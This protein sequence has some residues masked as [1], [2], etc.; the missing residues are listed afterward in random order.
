MIG[1]ASRTGTARNLAALRGAGWHLLVSARGALRTEGFPYALDNGAWTAHQK[2][3]PLCEDSFRRAVDL[4]GAGAQFI[5]LPDIVGGCH[6]SLSYSLSWLG[7]L[8]WHPRLLLPVQDGMV[9]DDVRP[10][11]GERVG[12]AVGG[13]PTDDGT[14]EWKLRTL[15]LWGRLARETGCYL[16]VLRVNSQRR[17]RQ[18]QDVG[19]HSFDGSGP[20]R[21]SKHL[22]VLDAAVRQRH[23]WEN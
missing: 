2:G 14:T 18:C 10:Y 4:L 21:F 7:R 12:L 20:S 23:L 8:A 13:A 17:I 1:Y 16:H 11:L 3:E 6:D 19:A 22:V 5:V 9:S 15:H